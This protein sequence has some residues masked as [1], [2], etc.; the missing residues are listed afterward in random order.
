METTNEKKNEKKNKKMNKTVKTLGAIV[1]TTLCSLAGALL[2]K[3]SPQVR[4]GVDKIQSTGEKLFDKAKARTSKGTT[5]NVTTAETTAPEA[6]PA[7]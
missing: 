5:E 4:T 6:A 1:G 7:Q 3:N 2:Y